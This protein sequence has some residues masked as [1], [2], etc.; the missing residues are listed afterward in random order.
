[1][2]SLTLADAKRIADAAEQ[3]ATEIGVPMAISVVDAGGHPVELR[4]MDGAPIA[5]GNAVIAKARTAVHFGDTTESLVAL[6][7]QWPQIV[8][9]WITVG[10][11]AWILSKG[12]LPLFRDGLLIGGVGCSGGTGGQDIDC[13]EAGRRVFESEGR[14]DDA[15]A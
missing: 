15:A 3:H 2:T 9:S 1:L 6:S 12:G 10:G 7:D 8:Q 4:R 11:G 13:A 14:S 5:A